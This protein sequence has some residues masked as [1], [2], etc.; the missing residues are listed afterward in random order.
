M[1]AK[2]LATTSRSTSA[3]TLT[4]SAASK[5]SSKEC[6]LNEEKIIITDFSNN[7]FNLSVHINNNSG[8]GRIIPKDASVRDIDRGLHNLSNT[9]SRGKI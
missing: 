6:K 3:P 8:K 9:M 5:E 7:G 1:S 2:R 4:L